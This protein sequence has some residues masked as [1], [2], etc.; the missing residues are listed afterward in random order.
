MMG[1]GFGMTAGGMGMERAPQIETT[2]PKLPIT[3]F[4]DME[5]LASDSSDQ[6]KML[7]V[8][9]A[10]L[11]CEG[12]FQH[13]P[14]PSFPFENPAEKTLPPV[15][16]RVAILPFLG[17][18]E[19]YSQYNFEEPWD[20]EANMKVLAQMP[21]VYA[22]EG[23]ASDTNMTRLMVI[24]G[25]G[26]LFEDNT[27]VRF[28]DVTDG[29]SNTIALVQGQQEIPWT[30]P[31]DLEYATDKPLP[32]FIW[33]YV[34]FADGTVNRVQPASEAVMRRFITRSAGEMVNRDVIIS[35]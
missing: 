5:P 28:Q 27:L 34:G 4:P 10:I 13:L 11:A 14:P 8:L 12:A 6:A 1:S 31:V 23:A 15:S 25:G 35:E 2:Y 9:K 32:N 7:T 30:Q 18:T 22:R 26:A 29:T 3:M 20:S 21:A 33:D 16:W 24:K 17:Y 19:L